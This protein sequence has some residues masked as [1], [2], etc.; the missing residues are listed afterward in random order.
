MKI[1]LTGSTGFL[2]KN[3]KYLLEEFGH[4]VICPRSPDLLQ[5]WD[6]LKESSR[7]EVFRH[8]VPDVI[9]HAAWGVDGANYRESE[10]N[11]EW[12]DASILFYEE[13]VEHGVQHFI[14]LGTFSENEGDLMSGDDHDNS[15]YAESKRQVRSK[16][17]DL[18]QRLNVPVSWLRIQYPYGYW[19]RPSRLVSMI[20]QKSILNEDFTLNSPNLAL[21]FIHSLDVASAVLET[22][23]NR[24][25]GILEVKSGVK[26]SLQDIKNIIEKLIAQPTEKN[27]D[28]DSIISHI[29]IKRKEK[30]WKSSVSIELGLFATI[31]ALKIR[32][33]QN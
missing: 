19:D 33:E 32:E 3:I 9:V 31:S 14:A 12:R 18:E 20:I 13:A 7:R 8:G 1:L 26:Y 5:N 27:I 11:S 21:D 16:I 4:E 28:I 17:F 2:G 25:F 29:E 6:M 24:I 15:R 23:E 30:N 22:I 10:V